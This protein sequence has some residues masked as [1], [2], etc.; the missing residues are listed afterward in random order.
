MNYKEFEDDYGF[1]C[2]EWRNEHG[3][4]HRAGDPAFI[5]YYNDG[6]VEREIFHVNGRT[7]RED[8]PALIYYNQ[9]GTIE[10]EFFWLDGKCIGSDEKGFWALWDYI[11]DDQRKSHSI[12]SCLARYS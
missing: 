8:G 11:A 4:L 9:C 10:S 1:M 3:N 7:H 12:L 2:K 5:R 6:S